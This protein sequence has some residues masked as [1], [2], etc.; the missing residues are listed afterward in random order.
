MLND[1]VLREIGRF[2]MEFS[3]LEELVAALAASIL[4]FDNW[5]DAERHTQD[6]STRRRLEL[7]G[8]RSQQ[9]ANKYALAEQY[10][11]L[12]TQVGNVKQLN[13]DRNTVLHGSVTIKRG[14]HPIVQARKGKI[15][16]T[17]QQLSKLVRRIDPAFH[18]LLSEY[19][20]FMD[21]VYT[22][23]AGE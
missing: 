7:L 6:L 2:A 12:S 8:E 4:E 5:Q 3:T 11:A 23:R 9:L 19:Y 10:V 18:G 14:K 16:L 13:N 21:A 22:A 1:E 17:S 20:A 15:K